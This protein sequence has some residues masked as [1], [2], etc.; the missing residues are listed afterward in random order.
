MSNPQIHNKDF[1]K[2]L[3]REFTTEVIN[4]TREAMQDER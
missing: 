2:E 4:E 3:E 1:V